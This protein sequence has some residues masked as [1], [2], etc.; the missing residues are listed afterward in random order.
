MPVDATPSSTRMSRHFANHLLSQS[1]PR[2]G[3]ASARSRSRIRAIPAR[4]RF[5]LRARS[6]SHRHCAHQAAHR[7]QLFFVVA[8]G[9]F[10]RKKIN[11][12]TSQYGTHESR[13]G[14]EIFTVPVSGSPRKISFTFLRQNRIAMT[15]DPDLPALLAQPMKGEDAKEWRTRFDRLAGSPLFAVVRQD[16]GQRRRVDTAHAGRPAIAAACDADRTTPMDHARRESPRAI[17]SVS[18]S[19]ANVPLT[20]SR[21]SF[22]ISSTASLILAQAGLNGPRVRQ[23]VRPA[24]SRGLPRNAQGRRHFPHR[25]RRHKISP[26]RPGHNAKVPG[27]SPHRRSISASNTSVAQIMWPSHFKG[28]GLDTTPLRQMS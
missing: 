7:I 5:R 4:Y 22:P 20:P 16:A 24:G 21:A 23:Q 18:W 19:K 9:R 1:S 27:R 10:D 3:A 15:D 28:A 13:G 8:D 6:R 12:Y 17:V 14:R 2:L 25:S 26:R 11:T